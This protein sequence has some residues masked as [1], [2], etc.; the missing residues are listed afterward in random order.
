MPEGRGGTKEDVSMVHGVSRNER[1]AHGKEGHKMME[2]PDDARHKS[3]EGKA[4]V[5]C[6][7]PIPTPGLNYLVSRSSGTAL[8]SSTAQSRVFLHVKYSLCWELIIW[9]E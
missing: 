6:M 1:R 3:N 9:A 2:H 5:T 4:L 8:L 7:L